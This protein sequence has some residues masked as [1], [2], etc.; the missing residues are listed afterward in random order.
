VTSRRIEAA[1]TR[2]VRSDAPLC[3]IALDS[4]FGSQANFT[5]AFRKATGTTPG[6][7]RSL[8]R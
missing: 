6:Q 5:R 4:G 3:A 2:L 1:R 8:Q 7:Y